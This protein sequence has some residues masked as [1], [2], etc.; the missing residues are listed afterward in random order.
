MARCSHSR[1]FGRSAAT[2]STICSTTYA[3]LV[4]KLSLRKHFMCF[5][6]V[7]QSLITNGVN[8]CRFFLTSRPGGALSRGATPPGTRLSA[9]GSATLG[10]LRLLLQYTVDHVFS[11]QHYRQLEELFIR[12]VHQKVYQYNLLFTNDN[13]FVCYSYCPGI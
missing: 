8:L 13:P 9:A 1:L 4:S 7:A 11:I 12:S 3:C 10:S 6:F 5:K 2:T